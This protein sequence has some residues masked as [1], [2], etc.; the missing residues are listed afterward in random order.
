MYFNPNYCSPNCSIN[1]A[2]TLPGSRLKCYTRMIH[3]GPYEM[4]WECRSGLQCEYSEL[5]ITSPFVGSQQINPSAKKAYTIFS[6]DKS[7]EKVF[8][9]L[10]SRKI[11]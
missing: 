8:P 4:V 6:G 11:I 7:W 3:F 5:N 2:Y 1:K 10:I 9:H